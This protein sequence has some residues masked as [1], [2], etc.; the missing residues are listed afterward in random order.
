MLKL[1][2][3]GLAVRTR[4]KDQGLES[5]AGLPSRTYSNQSR[6][7]SAQRSA[8]LCWNWKTAALSVFFRVLLFGALAHGGG[9]S[10][11]LTAVAIELV[12]TA[13]LAG[14]QGAL[15]QALRRV[16]PTW[17]STLIC[18][19]A[20]AAAN[21]PAEYVLHSALGTPHTPAAIAVSFAFTLVATR[22]SFVAMQRGVFVAGRKGLP[23]YEDLRCIP[24]LL[25]ATSGLTALVRA[26]QAKT[27]VQPKKHSYSDL[28]H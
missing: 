24:H 25:G 21:H 12:I 5:P 10:A 15:V 28:F 19:A 6:S 9:M 26:I 11:V 18:A 7:G 3:G 20:Y 17:L 14:F 22:F 8:P 16:N 1:R 4:A 13:T 27:R 23:F 2:E